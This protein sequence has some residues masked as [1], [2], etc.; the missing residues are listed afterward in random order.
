MINR[1]T[2][3]SDKTFITIQVR[4]YILKLIRLY[5]KTLSPDHGVFSK[6]T[7]MACKYNPTCSEYSYQAIE[8]YGVIKGGLKS[9]WRVLR[10]NP[11]S[12][13]GND[14]LE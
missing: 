5:Q 13:G 4:I 10:C 12:H 9:I 1:K 2:I 14:P 3:E 7:F 6:I 11:F 8:K